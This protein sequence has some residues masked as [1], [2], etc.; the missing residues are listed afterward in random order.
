M[1]GSCPAHGLSRPAG[2]SSPSECSSLG[3]GSSNDWLF[4]RL[5]LYPLSEVINCYNDELKLARAFRERF[6]DVNT[7]LVER[8][9]RHDGRH[10]CLRKSWH[11]G[12]NLA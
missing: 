5:C 7:S 8:P 3:L 12:M 10:K 9:R 1:W 4:Q 2:A 11:R 6:D